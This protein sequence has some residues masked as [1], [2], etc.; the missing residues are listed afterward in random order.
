MQR[1]LD[2]RILQSTTGKSATLQVWSDCSGL[3]TEMFA[4]RELRKAMMDGV[5]IDVKWVL[6]CAC[7]TDKR[8]RQY[9]KAN[10]SP[11]HCSDD[12]MHRNFEEGKFWCEMCMDNHQLPREG[13]D[14][15]VAGYPC[16]PWSRKGLRTDFEHPEIQPFLIG[17]QMVNFVRPAVWLM[18]TTG[19]VEDHRNG[20]DESALDKVLRHIRETVRTPYVT[21][22]VRNV[23]PAWSGY[24][25]RRPRV[26]ILN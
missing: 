24:P 19:G 5:G 10:H 26:F 25:T 13:I 21:Q 2:N 3:A 1:L 6:Y 22:V 7:E 4:S 14:V 8:A 11:A 9:I 23:T 16:S 15:Y 20:A 17:M 12:M 18:E